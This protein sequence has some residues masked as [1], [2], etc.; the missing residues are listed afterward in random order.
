MPCCYLDQFTTKG[1]KIWAFDKFTHKVC[2]TSPANVALEKYFYDMP[3]ATRP[4]LEKYSIDVQFMEM[5]LARKEGQF[6]S[7]LAAILK[8]V[9]RRGIS[10]LQRA[11][12]NSCTEK[13]K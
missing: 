7:D 5:A 3:E 1:G 10:H 6:N 4:L 9:E 8:I 2:E 13:G 11:M 12:L